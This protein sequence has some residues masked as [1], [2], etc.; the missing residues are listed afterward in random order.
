MF[1]DRAP[2]ISRYLKTTLYA[3]LCNKLFISVQQ[4]HSENC[5]HSSNSSSEPFVFVQR[6]VANAKERSRTTSVN[7]A[8]SALRTLIPTE[9]R[10][11]KLSKI[12]TLRLASSYIG[13][14]TNTI[15]ARTEG[16]YEEQVCERYG[17][18]FEDEAKEINGQKQIC[19]FCLT[20]S[21]RNYQL[22]YAESKRNDI[23]NSR[24]QRSS[25][26]S[27]QPQQKPN[28]YS[29]NLCNGF[30]LQQRKRMLQQKGQ[31]FIKEEL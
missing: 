14:L 3:P 16:D 1:Y 28:G 25:P 31:R 7:T 12:E 2:N 26:I 30:I 18:T 13:H 6:H 29:V 24:M 21:R 9:P 8:F 22:I 11:R 4:V 15:K 10:D 23:Y 17:C 5:Q 19:T 20:N 27:V